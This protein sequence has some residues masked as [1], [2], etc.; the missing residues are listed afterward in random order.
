[1]TTWTPRPVSALRIAASGATR[2]LPSPVCISAILPWWRTDAADQLDVEVAHAERP[3]HRLAGHREDL[4]QDVV[5]GL[6]DALVLAL[7]ALLRS[8]RRRSRSGWWSSSSDGSSGIGELADL[9]AELG[10]LG[11]DLVVGER[12]GSRVRGRWPRRRG[13][14]CVGPRGRSSR[15]TWKRTCMDGEVYGRGAARRTLERGGWQSR[16]EAGA[17]AERRAGRTSATAEPEPEQRR[18]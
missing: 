3:L 7:A 4:R 9:V 13:A 15:R 18:T 16:P 2:V 10:E 12:L 5:E 6:L 11:A 17:V 1:M 14:G 8:S